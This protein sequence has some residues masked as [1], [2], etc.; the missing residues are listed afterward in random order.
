MEPIK[1]AANAKITRNLAFTVSSDSTLPGWRK[2]NSK[3]PHLLK[4]FQFT[5]YLFALF[6]VDAASRVA[7]VFIILFLFGWYAHHF[8][9]IVIGCLQPEREF[10]HCD[11]GFCIHL[12]IIDCDRQLHIVAV[13]AM[14]A[15]FH[16][17]AIAHGP[18]CLVKPHLWLALDTDGIHYQRGVV[19]PLADRISVVT[20]CRN[21]LGEFT[22]IDPNRAPSFFEFIQDCD[23]VL[24]LHDLGVPELIKVG[25]RKAHRVTDVSWIITERFEDAFLAL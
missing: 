23:F 10:V 2:C 9:D 17:H 5:S 19:R 18:A 7:V 25:A 21:I 8:H 6:A 15:F 11:P 14:K 12:W 1:E 24:I 3:R 22:P 16:T 13:N 4:T 20:R